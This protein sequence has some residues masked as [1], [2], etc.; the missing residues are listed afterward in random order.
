MTLARWSRIAGA[1]F[2]PGFLWAFLLLAVLQGT[3]CKR[4]TSGGK[5][6]HLYIDPALNQRQLESAALVSFHSGVAGDQ[7]TVMVKDALT[8]ALLGQQ[9]R[10]F[11]TL[12][13]RAQAQAAGA[14]EAELFGKVSDVWSSHHKIDPNQAQ[15]L[16][17][18]LKT[19][20][21]LFA[22]IKTWERVKADW[23][24]DQSSYTRIAVAMRLVDGETGRMVWEARHD[25]LK[26]AGGQAV[27]SESFGQQAQES[28]SPTTGSAIAPEPPAFEVV[29]EDVA[30]VLVKSLAEIPRQEPETS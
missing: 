15:R 11:I 14:G 12:P 27:Y 5:P 29:M 25:L 22:S 6:S 13:E 21:L 3:A 18:V 28:V 23:K 20:G 1:F 2:G 10:L 16:C 26:E 30:R 7:A 24:A 4:A 19:D 8:A 17:D 9:E